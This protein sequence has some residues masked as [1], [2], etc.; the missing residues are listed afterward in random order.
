M[1]EQSDG[2]D[3]PVLP[4]ETTDGSEERPP[5]PRSTIL[6]L[7]MAV[8]VV[9]ILLAA[10]QGLSGI[11][12]VFA[13]AI[14]ALIGVRWVL[15]LDQ[16]EI[17]TFGFWVI[18]VFANVLYAAACVTPDSTYFGI[19]LI[20]WLVIVMPAIIRQ[21]ISW[22][23]GSLHGKAVPNGT[24]HAA[25]VSVI[26]LAVLPVLTLLT[27]WPLHLNF[28]IARP[29]LERLADRVD[30]GGAVVA[31]VRTGLFQIV[32][33]AVDPITGNVGLIIN[34]ARH[35]RSGL[36]RVRPGTP[37]DDRGPIDGSR[38]DVPLGGGWRYRQED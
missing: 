33:S 30:A 16:R 22:A 14:L 10:A 7:M 15:C 29:S 25:V 2:A 36:V 38:L 21:G 34:R 12:L 28:L 11:V 5:R 35:G 13:L 17:A 26:F 3:H 6:R 32:D 37:P 9:A 4:D 19:L 23:N 8:A 1:N 27:S 18:A 24:R 20:V 31:P